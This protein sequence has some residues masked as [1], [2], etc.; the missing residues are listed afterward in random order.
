MAKRPTPRTSP[1]GSR[2]PGARGATARTR[3]VP[4]TLDATATA[5]GPVTGA[6][7]AGGGGR[8]PGRRPRF[9]GRMGVLLLVLAVLAISYAS[10]LRAYLHQREMIADLNSDI[11]QRETAI[12]EL[13]RER[14]RWDDPAFVRS[15][16][17]ARFG[18]LMPGQ[19]GFQVLDADGQPLD[20]RTGLHDPE[21]V[22]KEMPT[23][24]WEEAWTSVEL[25]G[26][27]PP[28]EEEPVE[29]IDGVKVSKK[30]EQ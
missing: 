17:R 10:S 1:G 2:R 15:Q 30:A 9:T 7:P 22:V 26:N 12:A 28:P 5:L 27:P 24:W 14:Q 13:E 20:G 3:G 8:R 29:M 25:A 4:S 6:G 11:A 18:Y 19:T 21:D 23:P 16:A